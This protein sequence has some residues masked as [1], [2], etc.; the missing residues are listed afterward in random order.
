M[1]SQ[2]RLLRGLVGWWSPSIGCYKA[3][4][5]SSACAADGDTV[6]SWRSRSR[7]SALLSNS[8]G[9]GSEPAWRLLS[10]GINGCPAVELANGKIIKNTSLVV[11]GS[12]MAYFIIAG[13]GGVGAGATGQVAAIGGFQVDASSASLWIAAN[14]GYQVPS[15]PQRDSASGASAFCIGVRGFDDA[16]AGPGNHEYGMFNG[17]P[18]SVSGGLGV[19]FPAAY[20]NGTFSLNAAAAGTVLFGDVM[21][22]RGVSHSPSTMNAICRFLLG[23]YG[24]T[25]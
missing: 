12:S 10:N 8:L 7:G 23:R 14:G 17:V 22:F 1:F 25:Y 19:Q 9:T 24:L 5:E 20:S 6:Y 18:V 2:R 21:L 11:R 16:G 15:A 3:L 4:D 13:A